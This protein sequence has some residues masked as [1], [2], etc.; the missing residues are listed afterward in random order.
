VPSVRRHSSSAA[1][2]A[3]RSTRISCTLGIDT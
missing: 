1:I 3:E 2:D